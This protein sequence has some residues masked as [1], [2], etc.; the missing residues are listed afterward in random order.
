M[1]DCIPHSLCRF[2][3]NLGRIRNVRTKTCVMGMV[4]FKDVFGAIKIMQLKYFIKH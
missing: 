3:V 2:S 4:S 1:T